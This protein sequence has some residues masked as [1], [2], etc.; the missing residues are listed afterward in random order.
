[1]AERRDRP[2]PGG[3]LPKP[4]SDLTVPF[5]ALPALDKLRVSREFIPS[6]DMTLAMIAERQTAAV[7]SALTLTPEARS[8]LGIRIFRTVPVSV[9]GDNIDVLVNRPEFPLTEVL[10]TFPRDQGGTDIV[11][12]RQ[13]LLLRN[14]EYDRNSLEAATEPLNE[15]PAD[16]LSRVIFEIKFM[17]ALISTQKKYIEAGL[18]EDYT[19]LHH[20]SKSDRT[21]PFPTRTTPQME[22]DNIQKAALVLEYL[23]TASN[24][25]RKGT[26]GIVPFSIEPTDP[27]HHLLTLP[28]LLEEGQLHRILHP[29]VQPVFVASRDRVTTQINTSVL[30]EV[31]DSS[32][33]A[34]HY[35]KVADRICKILK[36]S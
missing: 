34:S 14:E 17:D 19:P 31:R 16:R 22:A 1:M 7:I 27:N 36:I 10:V 29:D 25:I 11:S 8:T 9:R 18:G 5:D 26:P 30:K 15:T 32:P 21:R 20:Q 24:L 12:A 3:S 4:P 6:R 2:Q 35:A 23:K 28:Y 33:G 13:D